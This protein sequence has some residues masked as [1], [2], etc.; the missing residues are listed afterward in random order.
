MKD[1]I[2]KPRQRAQSAGRPQRRRSKTKDSRQ[3]SERGRVVRWA[4]SRGTP[5]Q[6]AHT[7]C[8][9]TYVPSSRTPRRRYRSLPPSAS[10]PARRGKLERQR[11]ARAK[12]MRFA[13]QRKAQRKIKTCNANATK[14]FALHFSHKPPV[15][16]IGFAIPV[17]GR[18]EP[19]E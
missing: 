15:I 1:A 7:A 6:P 18:N 9:G 11:E 10:L 14:P 5:N 4:K 2:V 13:L 8:G 19:P 17:A 3:R 16:G 12:G